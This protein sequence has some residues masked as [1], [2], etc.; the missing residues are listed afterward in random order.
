MLLGF[1]KDGPQAVSD[2]YVRY[3]TV[4]LLTSLAAGGPYR[5]QRVSIL[6]SSSLLYVCCCPD[7]LCACAP[8]PLDQ[9][10][11]PSSR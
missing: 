2:F 6:E 10:G 5:L 7:Q 4:Q 8:L 11:L 3:H 1:L 9:H